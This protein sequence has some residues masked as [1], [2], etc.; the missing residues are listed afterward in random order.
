MILVARALRSDTRTVSMGAAQ[1]Q[2]LHMLHFSQGCPCSGSECSAVV[3]SV[4][5]EAGDGCSRQVGPCERSRRLPRQALWWISISTIDQEVL[6]MRTFS[7]CNSK[8]Y[9]KK[10]LKSQ[11][12]S[13]CCL[14]LAVAAVDGMSTPFSTKSLPRN[15]HWLI[16]CS[17]LTRVVRSI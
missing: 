17:L 5:F 4:A 6:C 3:P 8:V 9:C 16:P 1:A 11:K 12:C 15:Q 7:N 13:Q 2:E 10:I 14:K